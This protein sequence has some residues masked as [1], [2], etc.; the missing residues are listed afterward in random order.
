MG[1][2]PKLGHEAILSGSRN[3][4]INRRIADSNY[5]I[6]T[7][8]LKAVFFVNAIACSDIVCNVSF[9]VTL[10]SNDQNH[11][12]TIW[13]PASQRKINESAK[14]NVFFLE[15]IVRFAKF[16]QFEECH[17]K[18]WKITQTNN[19]SNIHKGGHSTNLRLMQKNESAQTCVFTKTSHSLDRFMF[20]IH[21]YVYFWLLAEVARQSCWPNLGRWLWNSSIFFLHMHRASWYY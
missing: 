2:D 18:N 16:S 17:K 9:I 21:T 5:F 12:L 10:Q 11:W 19:R 7:S 1:H 6:L 8:V 3:N 13:L 4:F 14:Q 15:I 20:F